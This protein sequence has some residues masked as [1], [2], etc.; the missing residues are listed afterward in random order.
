MRESL[1]QSISMARFANVAFSD[2]SLL[3]GFNQRLAKRQ[4]AA[5]NDIRR[6]FITP[7]ESGE[8]CIFWIIGR[9]QGYFFPKL[10]MNFFLLL[11]RLAVHF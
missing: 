6:Y 10:V 8:L 3:F 5:P 1:T 2:G 11:F 9:E 7:K 4:L